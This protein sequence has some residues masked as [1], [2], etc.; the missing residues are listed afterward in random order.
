MIDTLLA[1]MDRLRR[2]PFWDTRTGARRVL[3]HD[4]ASAGQRRRTEPF[5][6]LLPAIAEG[7]R[8]LPVVFPVHPRARQRRSARSAANCRENIIVVDPQP[9]LEFN[10]LV[11]YAK[12]Q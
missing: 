5:R 2:P 3:R 6:A 9:Y 4:A 10:Y 7:C 8:G 12:K 11:D 1:N